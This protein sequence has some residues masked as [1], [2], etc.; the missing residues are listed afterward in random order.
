MHICSYYIGN[1]LYKNL[2]GELSYTGITQHVVIPLKNKHLIGKNQLPSK[3]NTVTYYYK[4]ILKSYDRVFYFHKI[5]KQLK[6]IERSLLSSVNIDFVH[7]HTIFSDGGTAYKLYE[8]YGI[9]YVINVRNTDINFFFKYAIHL[10]PY[11]YKIL[12]NASKIVFI[13]HS[14]KKFLLSRLP[15]KIANDIIGKCEVIPN[16]MDD[17]WHKNKSTEKFI[18]NSSDVKLLFIGSLNKNK[19]LST[20]LKVCS[21]LRSKNYHCTVDIIGDGQEKE[22]NILLAKRLGIDNYVTF[23]GYVKEKTKIANIM[24]QAQIFIMPSLT[25]TF[26]IVYIEAMSRGLPVIYTKDQGIDGFFKDGE[27]GFSVN[28]HM[29]EEI[30]DK[31]L[32]I[33]NA[34][35]QFS[36]RSIQRAKDFSWDMISNQYRND[37]YKP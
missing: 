37:V 6:E 28:P 8:K 15:K 23:Y 24:D 30:A 27:V 12:T 21:L 3:Y 18:E 25:E 2:I 26:G 36:N 19:N 35:V 14:Y 16:A 32:K 7:A 22:A 10:R 13:S 1:E 11:M 31:I 4:D 20:V 17:F 33:L 29:E 5:G 9:P 34:Y